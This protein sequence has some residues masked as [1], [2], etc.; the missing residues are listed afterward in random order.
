MNI[1]MNERAQS[2]KGALRFALVTTGGTIAGLKTDPLHY[3]SGQLSGQDLASRLGLLADQSSAGPEPQSLPIDWALFSPYSIGSQNLT[4]SEM[5]TLRVMLIELN[6]DS[7]IDGILVTHGTDTMEDM[8]FFLY[9]TLPNLKKP[10][11]F[12]GAMLT[13]D[14]HQSDAQSNVRDATRLLKV[15]A[16]CSTGVLGLVMN[17]RFTPANLVQKRS[18]TGVDAFDFPASPID[19]GSISVDGQPTL[20][21]SGC[22]N[23]TLD[24]LILDLENGTLQIPVGTGNP[25]LSLPE[26]SPDQLDQRLDHCVVEVVYCTPNLRSGSILSRLGLERSTLPVSEDGSTDRAESPY[27]AESSKLVNKTVI[28]A[29]PGNGNIPARFIPELKALMLQGVRVVRASRITQS[30][31]IGGGELTGLEPQQAEPKQIQPQPDYPQHFGLQLVGPIHIGLHHSDLYYEA[32]G[33][34]LNQV[35]VMEVCRLLAIN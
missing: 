12:T 3:Q 6:S 22:V 29:A 9:L 30:A 33:L 4:W 25:I 1:A 20:N 17:G 23:R 10:I 8:L 7:S 28:V 31:L 14:S 5:F 24:E 2:S 18:T 15:A 11:L 35:V 26:M 16:T 32:Q 21:G 27:G 34:S 13:S 19:G